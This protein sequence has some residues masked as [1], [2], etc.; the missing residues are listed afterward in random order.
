MPAMRVLPGVTSP[1]AS[2]RHLEELALGAAYPDLDDGYVTIGRPDRAA[3]ETFDRARQ[4]RLWQV[5]TAMS[6]G[7]AGDPEPGVRGGA[8]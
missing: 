2:A 3:E 1:R 5:L 7:S 4:A 6:P 8:G